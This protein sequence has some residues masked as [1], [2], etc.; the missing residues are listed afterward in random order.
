MKTR[1]IADSHAHAGLPGVN[2]GGRAAAQGYA[3]APQVHAAAAQ[4]YGAVTANRSRGAQ[5]PATSA[6]GDM[7]GNGARAI[8]DRGK[9]F[10]FFLNDQL[11]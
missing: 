2:K 11:P 6:R 7:Q 5:G 4:E 9:G 1:F 3:S 10:C 8:Q